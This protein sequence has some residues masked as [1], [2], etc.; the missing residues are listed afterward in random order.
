[1]TPANIALATDFG[2]LETNSPSFGQRPVSAKSKP[3]IKIPPMTLAKPT[4]VREEPARSAAPGV[5]H[6]TDSGIL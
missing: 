1:M 2:I 6:T 5:D 4:P 3:V